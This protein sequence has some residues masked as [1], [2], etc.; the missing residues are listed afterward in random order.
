MLQIQGCL[1]IINN[2]LDKFLCLQCFDWH[3]WLGV[4]KSIRPVQTEWWD[5]GVVTCL[6][7][8]A[9]CLHTVELMPLHPQTPS[10]PVSFKSRLVSPL[11][12]WLTQLVVRNRP[13]NG[14][15][16]SSCCCSS[17]RVVVNLINF[18]TYNSSYL[19]RNHIQ[20]LLKDKAMMQEKVHGRCVYTEIT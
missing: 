12:Y 4:R 16:S 6:E 7:R 20:A 18:M 3:C 10:P 15:T 17:S 11:W 14:C 1:Q 13:L 8:G 9:D 19:P 2:K 5:A